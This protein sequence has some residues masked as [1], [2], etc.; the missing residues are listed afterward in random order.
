MLDRYLDS[1]S[2]V[3]ET[4][5]QYFSELLMRVP[6]GVTGA[7]FETNGHAAQQVANG[8][9]NGSAAQPKAETTVAVREEKKTPPPIT[10]DFEINTIAGGGKKIVENMEL[11]LTVPTATSLRYVPVKLLEENRRIINKFLEEQHEGKVSF[12]HL[13]G[14]AFVRALQAQP[15]L[16]D[17]FTVKDSSPAR[18]K[19][20]DVNLGIAIDMQ[21]RDG[22]RSLLVPNVKKA[23]TMTFKQFLKTYDDIV[24]RARA[25][26]LDISDFEG[27]TVSLTNPGTIGTVASV[28]RL[29][30]GQAIILATGSIEYPAEYQAMDQEVVTQL[31][32]SKVIQLTSTYDHRIIQGA[33]SGL[34]LQYIHELLTG[35]HDFY[36]RIFLDLGIAYRPLQWSSDRNPG[37]FGMDQT[38]QQMAKQAGVLQLINANHCC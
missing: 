17:G 35:K 9:R 38:R 3:D 22:S 4:W 6:N 27:T 2:L 19:R 26:K 12:T 14:W 34:L 21:K 29:M 18:V 37:L 16:N 33:E 8:A 36:D 10:G 1:P 5:K 31:G 32:V 24:K 30:S 7:K 28:P 20:P 25:N 11:S 13:I 15:G 23:N